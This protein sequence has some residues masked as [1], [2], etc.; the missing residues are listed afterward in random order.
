MSQNVDDTEQMS[1]WDPPPQACQHEFGNHHS[2]PSSPI[3]CTPKH[4]T[5]R[6]HWHVPR[7]IE[8]FSCPRA[9]LQMLRASPRVGQNTR[10][11]REKATRLQLSHI[12]PK[13]CEW[14][15]IDRLLR[16][17]FIR[18]LKEPEWANFDS[19]EN[20]AAAARPRVTASDSVKGH[21]VFIRGS[22][23]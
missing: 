20:A 3:A 4:D 2:V 13:A 23:P 7:I 22:C 14:C 19:A 12:V 15:A 21:D 10:I 18:Y 17:H 8:G 11:L 16:F 9:V 1:R 5:Y 6:S